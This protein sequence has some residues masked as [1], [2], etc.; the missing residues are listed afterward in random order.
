MDKPSK[1]FAIMV[2]SLFMIVS[3]L[4]AISAQENTDVQTC[5]EEEIAKYANKD[6]TILTSQTSTSDVDLSRVTSNVKQ[7]TSFPEM[8]SADLLLIESDWINASETAVA[9]EDIDLM[10]KSG[11][12]VI[13]INDNS[14]SMDA[15][16]FNTGEGVFGF[17]EE[18]QAYAK[19]I[20]EEGVTYCYSVSAQNT[21]KA[22]QSAYEWA[23]NKIISLN[24]DAALNTKSYEI[25]NDWLS[26]QGVVEI[27]NNY[28]GDIR[29]ESQFYSLNKN[30]YTYYYIFN[31]VIVTPDSGHSKKGI[32]FYNDVKSEMTAGEGYRLLKHGPTQVVNGVATV[33]FGSNFVD[34]G[35]LIPVEGI[36][37]SYPIDGTITDDS[38]DNVMDVKHNIDETSSEGTKTTT[39]KTAYIVACDHTVGAGG[40]FYCNEKYAVELCKRIASWWHTDFDNYRVS[41]Q[42]LV[43]PDRIY[44]PHGSDHEVT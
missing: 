35:N 18:A 4:P 32:D 33:D 5:S 38:H 24:K 41:H 25:T 14:L 20:S 22:I 30:N 40:L 43:Y 2:V 8:G 37:W 9:K 26:I 15:Q 28:H 31:K 39:V 34:N 44:M 23:E 6:V 21:D 17:A 29:E 19:I 42:V 36:G 10:I 11:T 13:L 27:D 3:T 7:V 1:A 12:P 16:I